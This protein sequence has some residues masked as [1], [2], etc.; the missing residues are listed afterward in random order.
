[1]TDYRQ[2][3]QRLLR[4][5]FQ[6][7]SA[8]LD[9]GIYA[10]MNQKRDQIEKFIEHELLDAVQEGLQIL[11]QQGQ[12]EAQQVFEQAKQEVVRTLGT[13]ALDGETLKEQYQDSPLG[14]KYL[15]AQTALV[16]AQLSTELEAQIFN[17]L[18]QFFDRYYQDGDFISQRRYGRSNKYA[19]PYNGEEVYLHWANFDQYY[20]KSGAYFTNYSFTV[21]GAIGLEKGASVQVK[22]TKVDVE[23]D[24]VKGDKRFFIYAESQQLVWDE[25]AQILTIP[26]EYRPLT[27]DESKQ[28]GTRDQQKK[29]LELAH[30]A[31]LEQL[32]S[33][34]LKGVLTQS[35]PLR[36]S[37]Q[38]RLNY[39]LNRY[40]AAN[41]RDFFIHK[42]LGGFLRRELDYYLK[43]E[44]IQLD[45]INLDDSLSLRRAAARSKTIRAIADK[46]ILFLDQI[47]AFQRRLFLKRKFILQSDYCLTLDKI[48]ED[49]R[50]SLYPDILANAKQLAEW[51]S[52]YDLTVSS[53]EELVA[54]SHLM[55][56]T[57]LFNEEFKARLLETFEDIDE[58]TDGLLVHSENFQALNLLQN[59][60]RG[61]IKCV[62]TDPPY[63][64]GGNDFLYKDSYRHSSWATMM[65]NRLLLAWELLSSNGLLS[66]YID[67]NEHVVAA[68]LLSRI[69][70]DSNRVGDIVWKNSSKNDQSYVSMQ[71]EYLLTAVK[72]KSE[73]KGTWTE[74]KE[75]LEEIYA[76]FTRFWKQ[77]QG[78]AKAIHKAALEWFAQFP[79][80]NPIS[81]SSHYSWMDEKGVYFAADI[82]GPNFGQ[83][84]YDVIHPTTRRVCKMPASGWRFPPETMEQR[85]ADNLI[86]FGNDETTIPNNKVYLKDA[87]TQSLTSIKYRDGRVASKLLSAMFGGKTFSNPKDVDISIRFLK[88]FETSEST[89][90]D[91]FAGTGTTGHAIML[92]NRE[93]KRR[94][95]YILVEM[96]DYFDSVLKP[97]IQKVAYS[98][99]WQHGKPILESGKKG[100]KQL[101][102]SGQSHM[103]HYIRLESYDDCYHNIRFK[104]AGAQQQLLSS[105]SDYFLSY[106]LEHE[107]AGSP[108]LLDIQQFDRPFDYRLNASGP[109][110]ILE[111]RPVDLVA[112][113]NFLLGLS[114]QTSR[115][116][117]WGESNYVRVT[118]T[119]LEGKRICVIWRTAPTD[120][121]LDAETKWMQETVLA[122][123]D[124][125][126]LYINGESTLPDALLIEEEFKRRMF[127][128]VR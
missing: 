14:E 93:D 117:K 31:I 22:I 54:H 30:A 18:Y 25:T 84:V 12:A 8:D 79:A 62:Y 29:L 61:K 52:L 127:E 60:Y 122:D 45:D 123:I 106:L 63:N 72:S 124:Y 87:E 64:T 75:G 110:G 4:A 6:F 40:A 37:E 46:I 111:P 105:M 35:D 114:V 113:F 70:G 28:T 39:H 80:S 98:S 36:D 92:L 23:R 20:V 7:D 48:P 100:K 99:E 56:D 38:D 116:F 49:T 41:T 112:T 96:G 66:H 78:D 47:E 67:E 55:L 3:L 10:I 50:A 43:S 53:E 17:D 82:S 57:A 91:F 16:G 90:L 128:G 103:F 120:D 33:N 97:R 118:G 27:E 94:R 15:V 11:S 95:K 107:T 68:Q 108:T 24:N 104:D 71:H 51:Q 19:V 76:A 58:V 88:A 101:F 1:M 126:K 13:R 2:Q 32:P 121:Q 86:H 34:A 44:V 125:D 9:F 42:D 21:P 73:N 69:F 85:I 65:S 26:M 74:R 109:G 77:F 119:D 89:I 81:D 83:Y 5:L 59:R 115:S 102:S